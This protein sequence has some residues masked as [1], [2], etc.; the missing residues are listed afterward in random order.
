MLQTGVVLERPAP[1]AESHDETI[2]NA[3]GTLAT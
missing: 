2:C 1:L 3:A